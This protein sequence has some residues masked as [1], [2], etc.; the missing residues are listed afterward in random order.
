[1]KVSRDANLN[2]ETIHK[3]QLGHLLLALIIGDAVVSGGGIFLFY[4]QWTFTLVTL[5][6][7]LATS[8]SIYGCCRKCNNSGSSTECTSLD[9]ERG[10]YVPP[11]LGDGSPDVS[12]TAKGS[13]SHEDFHTRKA[14]GVGGYAFQIIFQTSAGAVVLTDIV[15]WFILYPYLLSQNRGLSFFIVTM[16][17]VNAVC[18][19]GETIL[20]GLRYPFFRIGYFVMW[21]GIFVL[22]QWI[23]HACVSMPWPYPFLELSTPYAPLWYAGVG[24]MNIPCFGA[25]ALV[26]RMKQSLLQRLFPESFQGSS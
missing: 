19:L 26:I 15:F 1:M 11:T 5:Y 8:F 2:Q 17:S 22:F 9:A 20:N 24:L 7:G 12:N 23:L 6:F 21:T 10:T 14:A 4:T 3:I 25:F 13:D 16:H 18:L